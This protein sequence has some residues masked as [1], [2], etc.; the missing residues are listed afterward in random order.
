MINTGFWCSI[1]DF[2]FVPASLSNVFP[3][4]WLMFENLGKSAHT[5]VAPDGTS[6]ELLPWE[7]WQF[8]LNDIG[9]FKFTCSKHSNEFLN[10][11]VISPSG[12]GVEKKDAML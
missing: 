3:G 9:I 8:I 1:K 5:I 12:I 6:Q 11:T 10:V 7:M 4:D 2:A